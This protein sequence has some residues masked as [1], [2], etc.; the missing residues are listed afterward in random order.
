[1]QMTALL[2][3]KRLN[4]DPLFA[5]RLPMEQFEGAFEKLGLGMAGKILMYPNG[6]G[7]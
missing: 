2:K 7:K 5:E 6:M 4:L 1:V 3:A